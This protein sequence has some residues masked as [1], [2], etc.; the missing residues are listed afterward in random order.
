MLDVVKT[1]TTLLGN[2]YKNKID[3]KIGE[4]LKIL[5]EAYHLKAKDVA[6]MCNITYRNYQKYENGISEPPLSRLVIISMYTG[7]SLDWICGIS[8]E[9]YTEGYITS[10]EKKL[11]SY[12]INNNPIITIKVHN[13]ILDRVED[14]Q[15]YPY[16]NLSIIKEYAD[17]NK[18]KCNYSLAARAN[19]IFLMNKFI[20]LVNEKGTCDVSLDGTVTFNHTMFHAEQT[21]LKL[22]YFGLGLPDYIVGDE[23]DKGSILERSKTPIFNISQVHP[24]I[25]KKINEFFFKDNK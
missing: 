13:D 12:D 6:Q 21:V 19:I 23:V 10:L 18:R 14:I 17:I 15:I 1:I 24:E 11:W 20:D 25:D 8:N 16:D 7:I 4:R 3:L 22:H 5:R 2:E 9:P